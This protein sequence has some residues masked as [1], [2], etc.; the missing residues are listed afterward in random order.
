MEGKIYIFFYFLTKPITFVFTF[1]S[2][3]RTWKNE[4][5]Y[6]V[7]VSISYCSIKSSEG[8]HQQC[9]LITRM[10]DKFTFALHRPSSANLRGKALESCSKRPKECLQ[11]LMYYFFNPRST[12]GSINK[13]SRRPGRTVHISAGYFMRI[14]Y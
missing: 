9:R 13:P 11:N 2:I 3:I 10:R 4:V 6:L 14:S 1:P 5:V 12:D 7:A 8:L